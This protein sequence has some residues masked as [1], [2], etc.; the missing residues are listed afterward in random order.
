[1]RHF[2]PL[3]RSRS[4]GIGLSLVVVLVAGTLSWGEVGAAAA[5][6]LKLTYT[7]SGS[8]VTIT[9]CEYSACTGA[10]I[11]AT[12]KLR[13][14]L[15]D[16]V[17]SI[18]P[19]AFQN[20]IGLTTV[21]VGANVTSIGDGAFSGDSGLTSMTFYGDA[22]SFGA[23][24]FTGVSSAMSVYYDSAAL[25]WTSWPS[26][27]ASFSG[28]TTVL[29]IAAVSA[30]AS[31]GR[32]TVAWT[33][34]ANDGGATITGYSVLSTP[35]VT[36][37]PSCTDTLK[38]NCTF[39]GLTAG[40][41]YTFSVMASTSAT[42]GPVTSSSSVTPYQYSA[43]ANLWHLKSTRGRLSRGYSSVPTSFTQQVPNSFYSLQILPVVH[44]RYATVTVDGAS[45]RSGHWSAV[46]DLAVGANTILVVVTAQNGTTQK[47]YTEHIIRAA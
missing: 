11:P 30:V 35:T 47:T 20:D 17:T 9:G 41:S 25:G 34:P 32:V 37:P 8:V 43:N 22:P 39:V 4:I 16:D 1:M 46:I 3:R 38:L 31:T 40:T 14:G 26:A 15:I 10:F 24:D 33:A 7:V 23:G 42:S 28:D 18:S 6:Q 36:A 27:L 12:I 2:H 29:A 5:S 13:S 19:G 21:T 44:Q 45:V